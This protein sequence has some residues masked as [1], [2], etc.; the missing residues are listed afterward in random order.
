MRSIYFVILILTII[1]SSCGV[2][3]LRQK[4][5]QDKASISLDH[6][7]L[8]KSIL[9]FSKRV[10][11]ENVRVVMHDRVAMNYWDIQMIF[12]ADDFRS[13]HFS[14]Y[15]TYSDGQNFDTSIDGKYDG[16]ILCVATYKD[17][18]SAQHAFQEIKTRTQIRIAELEGQA[19]LLVEQVRIF[20]RIRISG[21]L[22]TQ[23]DKYVFYLLK[24]C[25]EPPAEKNWNDYENL[26]LSF[27]TEK[28]EEI[29]VIN[30]VCGKDAFVVQELTASRK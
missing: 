27:I 22:F 18:P 11:K 6:P 30:A 14:S 10:L 19:G 23:K 20:E 21:G 24:S 5:D 8:E 2:T 12:E 4:L 3:G 13:D 15:T 25:H 16:V 9:N 17:V 7:D 29:E 1:L 28:N 26:F